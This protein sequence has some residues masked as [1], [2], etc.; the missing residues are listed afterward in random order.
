MTTILF[1]ILS[2]ILVFIIVVV[3]HEFGHFWVARRMGVRVLRFSVG[4]GPILWRKRDK[5][6]TEFA[7]AAIPLGGYVKML[8][9]REQPLT[10]EEKPYAFDHKPV[11]KR[12]AVVIAGPLFNFLFAILAFA[13]VLM[14]GVNRVAPLIA[15]V[16]ADSPAAKVGIHAN[17]EFVSIDGTATNDWQSVYLNLLKRTGEQGNVEVVVRQFPDKPLRDYVLPVPSSKDHHAADRNPLEAWG[18]T[19]GLPLPAVLGEI[20]PH[21]AAARAGLQKEDKVLALDGK[22]IKDWYD[23]VEYVR[24]RPQKPIEF[25]LDRAGNTLT[26]T[27]TPS[28]QEIEGQPVGVIGVQ[29]AT[30]EWPAELNRTQQESIGS[31]FYK[32]VV[33]TWDLSILT[34]DIMSKMLRGLV[35]LENLA[36]PISIAEGAQQ[37]VASGWISFMSFLVLLSVNLGVINLLPIPMLDGGHLLY[38][39]LEFIRGKPV[40]EK[41]QRIGLVFGLIFVLGLMLVGLRNDIM[42][43]NK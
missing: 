18:I 6:G 2:F 7:I 3:V 34:F 12:M 30:G 43:L 24:E 28:Q 10:E 23:L 5:Y 8:D 11:G 17:D 32:S 31:A 41:T 25:T 14:I 33:N 38:Y 26:K 16:Q 29:I 39:V 36:G 20:V 37:S 15:H 40:S 35:G 22:P 42:G 19:L 21:G 13:L 27:V 9:G 1:S 4:F